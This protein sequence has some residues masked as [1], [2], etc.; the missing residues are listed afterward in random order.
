MSGEELIYLSLREAADRLRQR[1]LSPVALLDAMVAR[2]AAV[3]PRLNAYV[4]PMFD[5]ARAEAEAAEREIAAGQYRGPL[6]G[7]PVALKDNYWTRGVTT[8]AGAKLLADFVP[9]EDGAVVAKLRAAGAIISGKTNM[10]ELAI[11]GSTTN[12]HYGPT[13]NPWR[14]DCI[15]GGSS[16]GSAA[17]VAAGCCFAATGTD[18]AGSVRE[19]AA[20]CGLVGIK[21]TYGRVSIRGIMPLSWSLDHAGPLTR[22]V[23][24]GALVLQAI[25]GYDPQDQCSADVPVPDFTAELGRGVGGLRLGVPRPYFFDQLDAEVAATVETAIGVLRDLGASVEEVAFERA[26]WAPALFPLISRPEAASYQEELL[27]TRPDDY[28]DVRV[29]VELGK[30]VLATDYLRAQRLRT[31]MRQELEGLFTRV[32]ALVMPTT[33]TVAHPIGQPFTEVAGRP[34][35]NTSHLWVGLTVPFD[36]TGTPAVSVPCGFAANGLPIGLQIAGRAW[37]EATILRIAAAYEA[38]TPWHQQHPSL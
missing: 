32:D 30:L 19:P 16:G 34:V 11:G 24:D 14:L 15:P 28:G 29:Q 25:A 6:H 33:R 23:E 8:A 26:A 22:T 38:A 36:L 37:D 2:T 27:R 9:P 31:A 35:P 3:E 12:P 21:P 1:A 20:Y 5:Q 13:H 4:R 10:H 17:A 7:I 18:T